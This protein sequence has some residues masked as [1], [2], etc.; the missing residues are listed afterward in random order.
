MV[1]SKDF[2]EFVASLNDHKVEYLVVGGYA[3]AFHGHPR[4]TKDLDIWVSNTPKN[5][6]NLLKALTGFGFK[7]LQLSPKDFEASDTVIQLGF[8]PNRIDLLTGLKGVTFEE[9]YRLRQTQVLEG[10]PV[11]F[12]DLENLKRNKLA[13]GRHQDLADVESL[14]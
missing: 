12:I 4:Y 13:T 8:P 6:E 9:C 1:L 3:V 2:K 11:P 7:S 14:K 10:T 5:I